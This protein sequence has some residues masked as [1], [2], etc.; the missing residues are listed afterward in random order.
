MRRFAGA[1]T[2][3]SQGS[4]L[5][6]SAC[7]TATRGFDIWAH[8]IRLELLPLGIASSRKLDPMRRITEGEEPGPDEDLEVLL[9]PMDRVDPE[10]GLRTENTPG[11]GAKR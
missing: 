9:A 10:S 11:G 5:S 2:S 1:G 7:A 8:P 4:G 6:L 3:V